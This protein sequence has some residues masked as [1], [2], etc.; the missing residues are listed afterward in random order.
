MQIYS[1][2]NYGISVNLLLHA[3]IQTKDKVKY[4]DWSEMR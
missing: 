2:I 3:S 4:K 1:M